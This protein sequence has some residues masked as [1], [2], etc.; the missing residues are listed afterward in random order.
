[1]AKRPARLA[2]C[3]IC[4]EPLRVARLHCDRCEIA[5]EGNFSGSRLGLLPPA[6]QEFVEVFIA[7]G[8]SIKAVEAELGISYPT[9]KKRLEEVQHALGADAVEAARARKGRDAILKRIESGKLSARE[10][11]KLLKGLGGA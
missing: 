11:A 2:T 10:G 8:G 1:M 5:V 4:A 7:C 6:Q 9:V 3:P